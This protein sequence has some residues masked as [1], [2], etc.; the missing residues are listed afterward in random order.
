[1]INQQGT[2]AAAK[3]LQLTETNGPEVKPKLPRQTFVQPQNVCFGPLGAP[4]HRTVE[5]S[6][7]KKTPGLQDAEDQFVH[8]P[9]V[10]LA[11]VLRLQRQGRSEA[12]VVKQTFKSDDAVAHLR[13]VSEAQACRIGT[14]ED[15]CVASSKGVRP[16]MTLARVEHATSHQEHFGK[17]Q[18]VYIVDHRKTGAQL[19]LVDVLLGPPLLEP[20]LSF[21]DALLD[22]L[23]LLSATKC[24]PATLCV[25]FQN[26]VGVHQDNWTDRGQRLGHS[27]SGLPERSRP[28]YTM[29]V[30]KHCEIIQREVGQR[31]GT[32]GGNVPSFY[33]GSQTR[34]EPLTEQGWRDLAS[35]D[36]ALPECLV[37]QLGECGR[38][39]PMINQLPA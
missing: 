23:D 20:G 12:N 14:A 1:M 22:R 37:R 13:P 2:K 31:R 30:A 15:P 7:R 21:L 39:D 5:W 24:R 34:H 11:P 18:F 36:A 10:V 28:G 4:L 32:P 3:Q 6:F 27:L 17:R 38:P 16:K 25:T 9:V 35:P 33:G 26:D 29:L 19:A 8:D